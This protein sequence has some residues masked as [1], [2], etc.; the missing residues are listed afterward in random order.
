M[1]HSQDWEKFLPPVER[2]R[3]FGAPVSPQYAEKKIAVTQCAAFQD[4][5]DPNWPRRK[6]ALL[7]WVYR[8]M[9]YRLKRNERR[10]IEL[11]ILEDLTIRETADVL[12]IRPSSVSRSTA[13]GIEKLR[14][15]AQLNG[16]SYRNPPSEEQR[17]RYNLKGCEKD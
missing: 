1:N 11:H 3:D 13:R 7:A 17:L 9:R 4:R 12:R 14:A 8:T 5:R 16:I 15:Y 2:S 6:A 10:C